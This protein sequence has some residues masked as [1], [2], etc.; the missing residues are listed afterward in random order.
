MRV[1]LVEDEP[2]LA[3]TLERGLTREGFA[4]D[5]AAD[6]AAALEKATL[7]EYDVVVLDRALPIVHGDA[8]CAT[9][10]ERGSPSRILMLTASGTT[11]DLVDGLALGADDYLGKPFAFDELVARIRALERRAPAT[12]RVLERAGVTL[13][14]GK[15]RVTRDGNEIKLTPKEIAVLEQLLYADG[16]VVSAETLL[17][18]AWDEYADP[19]TNTVR[20]TMVTL[21]RKLGTPPVIETVIGAGYRIP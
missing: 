6:G 21:R 4:V 9:L 5:H 7:V 17:E 13:D 1:L 19:F 8:V 12:S 10:R 14:V 3:R 15:R 16:G 2:Q 20:V 18:R 11:Q